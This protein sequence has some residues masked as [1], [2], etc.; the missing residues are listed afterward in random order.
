MKTKRPNGE[1]VLYPYVY[2]NCVGCY[3]REAKKTDDH[4]PPKEA[5]VMCSGRMAEFI[6]ICKPKVIICVGKVATTWIRSRK[7]LKAL[8]WLPHKVH[9][10][11]IIHP[12]G[13]LQANPAMHPLMIQ[14]AIVRIG[15][16]V[17]EM[18]KIARG[19][20]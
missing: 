12:S 3:P 13:I 20:E 15:A 8:E 17:E 11:D 2:Y 14:R 18:E 5:L 10:A 1:V 19:E 9:L 6:G 16:A 7:V 4:A